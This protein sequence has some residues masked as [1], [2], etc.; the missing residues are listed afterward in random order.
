MCLSVARTQI[1]AV[2]LERAIHC[3][4]EPAYP[5]LERPEN[6]RPPEAR[7]AP[8]HRTREDPAGTKM[9]LRIYGVARPGYHTLTQQMVDR[10]ST[11]GVEQHLSPREGGGVCSCLI[12]GR[13]KVTYSGF[14]SAR[15]LDR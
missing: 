1:L 6:R 9:A 13:G 7:Q 4:Y 15:A 3:R 8:L 5:T 10:S 11:G 14:T 2:W 12:G